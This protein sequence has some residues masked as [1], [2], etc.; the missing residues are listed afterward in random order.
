MKSTKRAA[1]INLLAEMRRYG[2]TR[3]A[4]SE[5]LQQPYSTVCDKLNGT[6]SGFTTDEA[7]AIKQRFFPLI[8]IE[9]LFSRHLKN[10]A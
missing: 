4:L 1:Y 10:I 2:V 6:S 8:D 7:L 9:Q 5:F 3:K